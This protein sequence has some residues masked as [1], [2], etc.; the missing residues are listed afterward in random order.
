MWPLTTIK[1]Y[2]V[3]GF[4][5]EIVK[6]ARAEFFQRFKRSGVEGEFICTIH[7]SIVVDTPS[8]NVYNICT[9]LKDSIEASPALCKAWFDYDFS[10]PIWCGIQVGMNKKDMSEFKF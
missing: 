3:Q 4:G 1:N 6:L 5:A 7:D 10:L 8:K 2:P 9:M